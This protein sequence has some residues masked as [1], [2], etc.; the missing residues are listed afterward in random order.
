MFTA[1]SF[2]SATIWRQSRCPSVNERII[3]L[4]Y[5]QTM[6][7]YL[8]L[9][10]NQLSSHKKTWRKLKHI[11]LS[12]RSPCGKTTYC[13]TPTIWH[14]AKGK[15]RE[16]VRRSLVAR[17]QQEGK[18]EQ[19]EHKDFQGSETILYDAL[20]VNT[21]YCTFV[22]IYRIY[23][24]KSDPNANSEL[25][26]R[27]GVSIGSLTEAHVSLWGRMLTAEETMHVWR[28]AG[29]WELSTSCSILLRTWN[30]SKIKSVFK[31]MSGTTGLENVKKG[32]CS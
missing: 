26:V 1:A 21:C 13:T 28:G 17:D 10:K 23:T 29:S 7:Y 24:T 2:I 6:K 15:I 19:A 5:V 11:L 22:K 8:V 18:D 12:K 25:W 32:H 16:T 30:C 3:K 31:K 4:W 9:K 27:W 20:M 14:S